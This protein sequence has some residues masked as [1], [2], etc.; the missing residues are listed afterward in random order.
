MGFSPKLTGAAQGNGPYSTLPIDLAPW[1]AH[2]KFKLKSG[3]ESPPLQ[4]LPP[5]STA[6]HSKIASL[7]Q[8]RILIPQVLTSKCQDVMNTHG[9]S[10]PKQWRFGGFGLVSQEDT[11]SIT[12]SVSDVPKASAV[13]S[14]DINGTTLAREVSAGSGKPPGLQKY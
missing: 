9:N 11:E 6:S 1:T 5:A 10:N 14:V 13:T 4:N 7:P 12:S 8:F 3:V 2:L